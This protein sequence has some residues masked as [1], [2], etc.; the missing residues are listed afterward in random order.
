MKK[1]FLLLICLVVFSPIA[2]AKRRRSYLFSNDQKS[3]TLLLGTQFGLRYQNWISWRSAWNYDLIYD[4]DEIIQ[5]QVNYVRYL[6]DAKD[7]VRKENVWNSSYFYVG[8]GLLLGHGF[9][10]DLNDDDEVQLGVRGFAGMDYLFS[11]SNWAL[12]IEIAG[13][14]FLS[15]NEAFGLQAF[16]GVSY[17]W[18]RFYRSS[19]RRVDGSEDVEPGPKRQKPRSKKF[20]AKDDFEKEFE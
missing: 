7:K 14:G 9:G 18:D 1:F 12:R 20:K 10:E 4:T 13:V 2:E 6:Y 17:Q 3:L 15:A 5:G 19:F 8:P 11:R 16:I